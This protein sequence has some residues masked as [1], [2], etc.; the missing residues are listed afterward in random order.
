[1]GPGTRFA[2]RALTLLGAT[3]MIA[4][5][6]SAQT[7]QTGPCDLYAAGGQPC[8]AAH[9]T[10]RALY[11]AYTGPLYQVHAPVRQRHQG[12]R[13]RRRRLRRR[14]RAG[15]V[16]RQHALPDHE[17][18][19]PVADAQRPHAGAARRL[20]RPRPGRVQQLPGRRHGADHGQRPQGLRRLHRAGH[21]PAQQ[22][23]EGHRG[24]RSGRG[25][26]LGHQRPPLQRAAAA[27]T[28]ATPRSTA[29]TTAT[30][31]WRPPT[32][33]TPPAGIAAQ[34]PGPWIMTDQENNLVGC[35]NPGS[36]SK[37]CANLP[38]IDW[39]FVTG[40]AKG[41]PHHWASLGGDAQTGP[42]TTMFDGPRDRLDAMTRCASRARS[43]SATAATTASAPRAPS[44]RASMTT[45]YPTDATDRLVQAN[46]AAA[47]YAVQPSAS[48]PAPK[49]AR[50]QHADDR[51]RVAG[52][53]RQRAAAR[54]HRRPGRQAA[55]R[56]RLQPARLHDLD[57]GQPGRDDHLVAHLRLRLGH[58][59]LHVP[60]RER[61]LHAALRDHDQRQRAP[62]A[63]R[64]STRRRRC[65][66]A[67][68]RTSRSRCRAAPAACTSTAS[69]SPRTR[70]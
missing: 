58:R 38:T 59:H 2:A 14:R 15:R 30:A 24:R 6:A 65:R 3:L 64:S 12:R 55:Q 68:G 56:H 69:R 49:P 31:R 27:S 52:Q 46:V 23:P 29:A 26:L 34:G 62:P 50:P 17:A 21:G 39:R 19:R 48:Q 63:S 44:T 1:M 53:V 45:G 9:S 32:T 54:H 47:K 57:L 11:S 36:T 51:P 13:G 33:A 70:R 25:H 28:T 42:L 67:S 41:E 8:V 16:L 10:T 18:L 60:G 37:L 43:C 40:I 20:Q 22:Q 35:V 66:S 5:P 4:G 61:R 7:R